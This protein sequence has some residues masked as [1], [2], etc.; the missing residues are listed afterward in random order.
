MSR[1]ITTALPLDNHRSSPLSAIGQYADA[2]QQTGAVDFLY[3]WDELS[4]WF[5]KELWT[6][7]NSPAADFVDGGALYDPF[8]EAAFVTAKN[9]NIGLRLSTDS[10][11]SGPAEL[12]RRLLTLANG[13]SAPVVCAI[14]AG[15]ARQ[16]KPFG[17]KRAEGLKRL[18][19][20]LALV[21]KLY[22]ANE[23]ISYEGHFWN[24]TNA[25]MGDARPAIRPEFWALGGGP[26]LLDIAAK[27]ADGFEAAVPQAI[28]NPDKYAQLARG[29]R[30]K[31]EANGRDPAKF[32]MGIWLVCATHED[33]DVLDTVLDNPL[34]KYFAACN[35]RVDGKNWAEVGITPVMP[36]GWNY[37]THWLP[38]EQPAAEIRDIVSRTPKDLVR[39]SFY[40]GTPD[41]LAKI[42]REYI[43]AGADFVSFADMTPMVL[44]PAD[45]MAS[46]QRGV[47]IFRTL[48]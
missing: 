42:S 19:D 47:K 9:P 27:H 40:C 5:P 14:G 17:Y 41:H 37:P 45:A 16:T 28:T 32:G 1:P 20:A 30:E 15:E 8:I 38:A 24:Y 18:E 33:A 11:R 48:K 10:L 43:D 23:P 25:F 7:K 34:I 29:L 22:D 12:L 35:G 2:V 4:T 6:T 31:V 44:G 3:L 26:T 13:T 36:E 21:R 46:V 39:K